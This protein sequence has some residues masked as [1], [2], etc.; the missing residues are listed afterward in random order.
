VPPYTTWL[1]FILGTPSPPIDN[2]LWIRYVDR[3]TTTAGV[4]VENTVTAH[5]LDI[6]SDWTL[7]TLDNP[8]GGADAEVAALA[9]PLFYADGE[10]TFYVEPALTESLLTSDDWLIP[11]IVPNLNL[12]V[13]RY[14]DGLYLLGQVA[15]AIDTAGKDLSPAAR[16]TVRP[17]ADWATA[18][19]TAIT[20]QGVPVT[21]PGAATHPGAQR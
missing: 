1:P 14:W 6:G 17:R 9:A 20:Y 16:F 13:D 21:A 18:S 8:V 4:S 19:S 10:H 12:D 3:I 15:T 2:P 7:R 11:A 5:I